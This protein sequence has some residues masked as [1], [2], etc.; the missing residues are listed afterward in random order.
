MGKEKLTLEQKLAIAKAQQVLLQDK[1]KR[2]SE[3]E[4]TVVAEIIS[5]E[6]QLNG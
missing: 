4:K 3:K 1:I 5:L 6:K 2:L